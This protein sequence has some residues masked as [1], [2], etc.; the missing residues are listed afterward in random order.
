[1]DQWNRSESPEKSPLCIQKHDKHYDKMAL[2]ING[3]KMAPE[4]MVL[5]QKSS[6]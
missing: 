2:Q 3:E 1:M 6:R 4:S 5:K